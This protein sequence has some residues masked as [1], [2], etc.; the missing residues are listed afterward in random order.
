MKSIVE[1][2]LSRARE[3]QRFSEPTEIDKEL[4]DILIELRTEIAV[5]GCGGGGSNTVTR[6]SE[7]GING[8]RLIALNTD[9]QHLIRTEAETR[10]LIGRQRTRGLGA[11]SIP[12]V[13]EEAAL[14]NEDEIKRA[15]EGCDMVFITTGPGRCRHRLRTG[16][17]EVGPGRGP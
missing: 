1:E 16:G 14:E 2:A 10:I 9:A 11:G 7:E 12:Q 5:V 13:G 15:V 3:E 6:M 17:R 4:E 8:A